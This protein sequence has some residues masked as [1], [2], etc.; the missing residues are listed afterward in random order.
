MVVRR[1]VIAVF[2]SFCCFMV[3]SPGVS[4]VVGASLVGLNSRSVVNVTSCE[5]GEAVC[6]TGS[7][8][9]YREDRPLSRQLNRLAAQMKPQQV[10]ECKGKPRGQACSC[11]K[12]GQNCVG[13]CNGNLDCCDPRYKPCMDRGKQ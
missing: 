6:F 1:C 4:Q 10:P 7:S 13:V 8:E 3:S 11:E 2:L 9:A 12:P 5:G